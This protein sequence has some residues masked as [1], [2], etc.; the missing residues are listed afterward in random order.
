MSQRDDHS[1]PRNPNFL[2]R[3][4]E[5]A[6]FERAL[7]VADSMVESGAFLNT[8]EL[9]RI[10]NVLRG[11]KDEPWREGAAV[12]SLPS[13]REENLQ[14]LA[15][16]IT[17]AKELLRTA[18][19]RATSGEVVEAAA[20][21]YAHLVL[22]HVFKDANRRTAVVAASYLLRLHGV[23]IS[24]MGLHE[25]GLGDLRAEGQMEALRETLRNAVKLAAKPSRG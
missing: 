9:A 20:D 24:A 12:C 8:A 22:T 11:E 19:D 21:L 1:A 23:Q 6:R 16:P 7:E 10:N 14:I 13:G 18:K 4:L 17:K 25:L 15:D 5:R 2:Q 3:Q